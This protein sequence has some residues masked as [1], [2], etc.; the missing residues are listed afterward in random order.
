MLTNIEVERAGPW[1]E[2]ANGDLTAFYSYPIRGYIED[3]AK[4]SSGLY[5]NR[6]GSKRHK[7][8]HGKFHSDA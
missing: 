5:G 8:E 7:L 1:E 3:E 2:K 4:L 6:I